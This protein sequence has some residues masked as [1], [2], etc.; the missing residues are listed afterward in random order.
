MRPST[1]STLLRLLTAA[2]AIVAIAVVAS[3]L[4]DAVGPAIEGPEGGANGDGAGTEET[5]EEEAIERPPA[6]DG[7][8]TVLSVFVAALFVVVALAIVWYLIYDH[9]ELL[10]RAIAGFLG[11]AVAVTVL[12]LAVQALDPSRFASAPDFEFVNETTSVGDGANG[13]GGDGVSGDHLVFLLVILTGLAV[14]LVFALRRRREK[15]DP[16]EDPDI[17]DLQSAERTKTV[18][19]TTARHDESDPE[20]EVYRHWYALTRSV[21][22]SVPKLSRA[23]DVYTPGEYA[24]HATDVGF[25][26]EAVTELR[27]QFESVRYGNRPISPDVRRRALELGT[28]LGVAGRD[29]AKTGDESGR[30]RSGTARAETTRAG[31]DATDES[32]GV[33]TD[34]TD[35]QYTKGDRPDSSTGEAAGTPTEED[36]D[37]PTGKDIDTPAGE[38]SD[39]GGDRS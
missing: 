22:E 36:S 8:W 26:P 25:D 29:E 3:T 35:G 6:S 23:P 38:D 32:V 34:R 15:R 39:I 7:G 13:N 37:T 4:P 31:T 12:L 11:V 17:P 24:S 21:T 33:P 19:E 14:L 20:N 10:L 28:Q 27:S 16:T 1:T 5:E 9:R 2:V 30:G 18:S